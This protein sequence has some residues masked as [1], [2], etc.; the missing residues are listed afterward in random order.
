MGVSESLGGLDQHIDRIGEFH[1]A[2]TLNDSLQIDTVHVFHDDVKLLSRLR[3]IISSHDVGVIELSTSPRLFL[4][5]RNSPSVFTGFRR[6]NF[7]R[8]QT[9]HDVVFAE[10]DH[11]HAAFAKRTKQSIAPQIESLALASQQLVGLPTRQHFRSNQTVRQTCG[12]EVSC[13]GHQRNHHLLQ[14]VH[15]H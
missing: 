3:E 9:L 4:E 8:H 10:V 11:T 1:H 2:V 6:K 5:S 7:Q 15:F 13:V 12:V 14:V